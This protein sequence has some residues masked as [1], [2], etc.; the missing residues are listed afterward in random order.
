MGGQQLPLRSS[1][2]T[3]AASLSLSLSLIHCPF[4]SLSHKHTHTHA[5]ETMVWVEPREAK[6]ELLVELVS[7][8]CGICLYFRFDSRELTRNEGRERWGVVCNKGPRKTT[9]ASVHAPYAP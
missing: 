2:Q 7:I 4:H 5:S 1:R 3:A 8:F 9:K 6:Q